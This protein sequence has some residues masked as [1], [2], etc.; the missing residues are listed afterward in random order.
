M[1]AIRFPQLPAQ[2]ETKSLAVHAATGCW[3][4][5]DTALTWRQARTL[6]ATAA[7][8]IDATDCGLTPECVKPSH[9]RRTRPPAGGSA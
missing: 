3:I 6:I 7:H 8:I 5:T 4:W 9:S 1:S 2:W